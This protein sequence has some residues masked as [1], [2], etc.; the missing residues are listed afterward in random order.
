MKTHGNIDQVIDNYTRIYLREPYSSDI[1]KYG[2]LHPT[3]ENE[4]LAFDEKDS[5]WVI[6]DCYGDIYTFP[7]LKS[8]VDEFECKMGHQ[9]WLDSISHWQPAYYF[10]KPVQLF[11]CI[12]DYPNSSF[13]KID[14]A[15]DFAPD[16]THQDRL[17]LALRTIFLSELEAKGYSV[18]V[19]NNRQIGVEHPAVE[20][21]QFEQDA[22]SALKSSIWAL[23][24][25]TP[26]DPTAICNLQFISLDA[27]PC[28]PS[29]EDILRTFHAD[30]LESAPANSFLVPVLTPSRFTR[31]QEVFAVVHQSGRV[32]IINPDDKDP[33]CSFGSKRRKTSR[34]RPSS[35]G[36]GSHNRYSVNGSPLRDCF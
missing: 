6:L 3:H 34:K 2:W 15:K 14:F 36:F 9:M 28:N 24:H 35:K 7:D 23:S 5:L 33:F 22:L 19:L 18:V 21:S 25:K 11:K 30:D 17:H 10:A 32:D 13:F 29:K 4:C 20:R 26:T 8:A 12:L 31:G 27:L 1:S 16:A